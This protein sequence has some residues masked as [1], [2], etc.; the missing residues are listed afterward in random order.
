MKDE[1]L[2][3]KESGP[4]P[5]NSGEPHHVAKVCLDCHISFE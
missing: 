3:T 4:C 2:E 1:E 5:E